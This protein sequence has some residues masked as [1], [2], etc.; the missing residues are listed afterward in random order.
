MHMQREDNLALWNERPLTQGLT[1]DLLR[2]LFQIPMGAPA[3]DSY[4][5]MYIFKKAE[6]LYDNGKMAEL[7]MAPG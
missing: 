3:T 6:A 1:T 2:Y 4:R 5:I 7:V